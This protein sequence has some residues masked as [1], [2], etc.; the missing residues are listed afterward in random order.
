MPICIKISLVH[1]CLDGFVTRMKCKLDS[2][3]EEDTQQLFTHLDAG[4]LV[5]DTRTPF[6]GCPTQVL[7]W[8][9]GV[10]PCVILYQKR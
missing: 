4:A 8:I 6:L 10:S 1:C 3:L 2:V 5:W 7:Q 9:L